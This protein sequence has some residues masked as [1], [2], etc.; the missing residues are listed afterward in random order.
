MDYRLQNEKAARASARYDLVRLDPAQ[1]SS[2]SYPNSL[3]FTPSVGREND[4][5]SSALKPTLARHRRSLSLIIFWSTVVLLSACATL[6]SKPNGEDVERAAIVQSEITLEEERFLGSLESLVKLQEMRSYERLA[7]R[8]FGNE[9]LRLGPLGTAIT[10]RYP[11]SLAGQ[12]ALAKFYEFLDQESDTDHDLWVEQIHGLMSVERTG[13]RSDPYRAM[14]LHD[15][16][17]FVHVEGLRPIG[18]VYGRSPEFPLLL[19]VI[20]QSPDDKKIQ[21]FVFEI[22]SSKLLAEGFCSPEIQD[23]FPNMLSHLAGDGDDG[24][25]VTLSILRVQ[26]GPTGED[27]EGQPSALDQAISMLRPHLNPSNVLTNHTFASFLAERAR[28]SNNEQYRAR[29]FNDARSKYRAAINGGY[30]DSMTSLGRLYITGT[31]GEPER[32]DGVDLYQQ[33]IDLGSADAASTL[34]WVYVNGIGGIAADSS[35]AL[36]YLNKGRK[37]GSTMHGLDYLRYVISTDN[38]EHIVR[39]DV[40]WL[41]DLAAE[42]NVAA[43]I[44]LAQIY[45]EGLYGRVNASRAVY[46]YQ[47][48]PDVNPYDAALINEVA[49]ILATSNNKQIRRAEMAIDMMSTMMLGNR[50]ARQS[51]MYLDTWAAAHAAAAQ[52]R[53]AISLQSEAIDRAMQD[54]QFAQHLEEMQEHLEAFRNKKAL[55]EDVP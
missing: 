15:A 47:Q 41:K 50:T 9:P 2:F 6:D 13:T 43:M 48:V 24:A 45:A 14:N 35:Q 27:E 55:F 11:A 23:C 8:L 46:W 12:L 40:Q 10:D 7:I 52:W 36:E 25:L 38:Q 51:P 28:Q 26:Q 33:A 49:W 1:V 16:L 17:S 22:L 34:G 3:P 4:R 29:L 53:E 21:D 20:A 44:M 54:E 32:Q 30:V 31:Y 39:E 42:D 18:Y 19:E 5:L 37:L